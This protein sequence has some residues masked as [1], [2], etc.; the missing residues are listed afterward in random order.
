MP[1]AEL[2]EL[3][4]EALNAQVTMAEIIAAEINENHIELQEEMDGMDL[5]DILGICGFSL[6]LGD[7]ASLAHIHALRERA[8]AVEDSQWAN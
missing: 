2:T 6:A 8:V 4:L 5:L 3:T 1:Y 7:I